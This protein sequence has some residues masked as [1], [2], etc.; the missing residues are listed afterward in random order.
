[1]FVVALA[2]PPNAFALHLR[3]WSV[4]CSCGVRMEI[5]RTFRE[6][7]LVSSSSLISSLP[8]LPIYTVVS[9]PYRQPRNL[10]YFADQL[11]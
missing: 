10:I 5:D 6:R 1:M 4:C 9:I 2:P 3:Q 7:A 8:L 11:R